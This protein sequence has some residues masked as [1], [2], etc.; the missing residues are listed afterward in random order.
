MRSL[1][2][3]GASSMTRL[4]VSHTMPCM[5]SL[6][7]S[8]G[9]PLVHYPKS[10]PSQQ[11]VQ[12]AAHH[13]SNVSQMSNIYHINDALRCSGDMLTRHQ[14]LLTRQ[15]MLTSNTDSVHI[16]CAAVPAMHGRAPAGSQPS[17]A[18]GS[19]FARRHA[20]TS[21]S[22]SR[23]PARAPQTIRCLRWLRNQRLRS[24]PDT[25]SSLA[26]DLPG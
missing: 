11:L 16:I 14:T 19:F 1:Y 8:C 3:A 23:C 4:S 20:S 10:W 18:C 13:T 6:K 22:S 26:F 2:A 7:S 24:K 25:C 15:G 5:A 9:L 21:S 12:A 17:H